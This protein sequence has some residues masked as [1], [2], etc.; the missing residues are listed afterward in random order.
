[1]KL[2]GFGDMITFGLD[3]YFKLKLRKSILKLLRL[4]TKSRL[5]REVLIGFCDHRLFKDT[6]FYLINFFQAVAVSVL[7]YGCTIWNN[8]TTE[9]KA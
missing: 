4:S 2:R 6:F 8:E 9:K 5:S 1:M 7:L 3:Q